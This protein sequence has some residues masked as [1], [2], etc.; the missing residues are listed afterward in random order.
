[1]RT[2]AHL[3]DWPTK[4]EWRENGPGLVALRL[5]L[6][7]GMMGPFVVPYYLYNRTEGCAH[8]LW[9]EHCSTEGR[10]RKKRKRIEKHTEKLYQRQRKETKPQPLHPGRHRAL[11]SYD[12]G[13]AGKEEI[14]ETNYT[15]SLLKGD[16]RCSLLTKLSPALRKNIWR[17]AVGGHNIA[18]FRGR[19]RLLHVLQDE[20]GI[21]EPEYGSGMP[22]LYKKPSRRH[23]SALLKTCHQV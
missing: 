4:E 17:M 21:E 15:F 1:M 8:D 9:R 10:A 22:D 14:L 16:D 5:I 18:V 6:F 3:F 2:N 19:G 23:L 11:T 13:S 12:I 7:W 20:E